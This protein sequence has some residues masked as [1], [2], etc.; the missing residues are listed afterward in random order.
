MRAGPYDL[1]AALRGRCDNAAN[2]AAVNPAGAGVTIASAIGRASACAQGAG[3]A[4]RF[5]AP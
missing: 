1:L 5:I 4:A 2:Q 3:F